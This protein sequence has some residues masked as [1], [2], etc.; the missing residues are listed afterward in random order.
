MQKFRKWL[1]ENSMV[2]M[3]AVILVIGG[4]LFYIY[5]S[6]TDSRGAALGSAYYLDRNTGKLYVD[7]RNA[8]PPLETSSGDYQGEPAGVRAY[9]F[10]CGDYE[11]SY[12]GMTIEEVQQSGAH[13][14]ALMKYTPAAI[15]AMLAYQ[16]DDSNPDYAAMD[17]RLLC[18]PGSEEWVTPAQSRGLERATTAPRLNCGDGE[19]VL[20]AFPGGR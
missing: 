3:I 17:Q 4:C 13:V 8:L 14:T 19:E 12:A 2:T 10:A 1:E 20:M 9:V 18:A 7:D 15:Q 5:R 6:T 11:S 16:E